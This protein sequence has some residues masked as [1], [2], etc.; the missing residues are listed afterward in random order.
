MAA[1]SRARNALEAL[2]AHTQEAGANVSEPADTEHE[3]DED[4]DWDAVGT[5]R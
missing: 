4:G 5:S 1:N 3:S 2:L